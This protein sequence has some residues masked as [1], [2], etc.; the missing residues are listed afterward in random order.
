[1]RIVKTTNINYINFIKIKI[2]LTL[3]YAF[4]N[5][6]ILFEILVKLVRWG[7]KLICQ[8]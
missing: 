5:T 4:I 2:L 1:M 8:G 7:Q 6:K 3:K